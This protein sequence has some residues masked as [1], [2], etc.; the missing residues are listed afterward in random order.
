MSNKLKLIPLITFVLMA[1]SAYAEC[2]LK[3]TKDGWTG[4]IKFSCDTDTNLLD[5]P[6]IFKISDGVKATSVWGL[7]GKVKLSQVGD[8]VTITAQ[9]WW[10]EGEGQ[11]LKANKEASISFSP[12]KPNFTIQSF[13]V[14]DAQISPPKDPEE[15]PPE[16]P[17]QPSSP[18]QPVIY[19][20]N[21]GQFTSLFSIIDSN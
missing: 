4:N 19:P 6:I 16:E 18:E 21:L 9:K 5:N 11:I 20:V 3:E 15:N 13:S 1:S 17:N 14:G 7:D 2:R 12:S 10:P 8:V